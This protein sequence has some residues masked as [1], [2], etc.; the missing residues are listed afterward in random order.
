MN[1]L[2][3]IAVKLLL[4]EKQSLFSQSQASLKS[5]VA[6]WWLYVCRQC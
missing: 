3:F 4:P 5:I 1:R 2:K 6:I